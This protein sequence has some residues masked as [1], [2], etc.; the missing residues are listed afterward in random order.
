MEFNLKIAGEA[1]HGLLTIELGLVEILAQT[2]YYFFATKKYMSRIR[3]GHNYHMIRIADR[4]VHTL[5]EDRWEL[6]LAFDDEAERRHRPTLAQGGIMI[7]QEEIKQISQNLKL[8]FPDP[9]ALNV[10]L[11]GVVLAMIGFDPERLAELDA[12]E[13]RKALLAEGLGYATAKTL[14]GKYPIN[15]VSARF[16]RFDGNQALGFGAILGGCQFMAAYPMTPA[17]SIMNYFASAAKDLPIHFEQAED[18]IAA[19][20]M[21]LGASYAGLRAMTASSGGGFDLM[22]EG[23]SLAGM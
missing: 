9:T 21:A 22:T 10:M 6:L 20:N 3:G 11:M 1:G 8:K 12:S 13:E 16:L 23:L 4:P 17:T 5:G 14:V 2:G 15:P 7:N 18:E 19:V